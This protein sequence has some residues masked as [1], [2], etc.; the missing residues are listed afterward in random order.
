MW[1]VLE[2]VRQTVCR[3]GM[4]A[5][6]Q[7]VGVA[8]SGG[9]DSVCLLDVLMALAP[10]WDLRLTVL[11][12]DHQLRGADSAQDAEFV[13]QLAASLGLEF[14]LSRVD[15]RAMRR[16]DNLE[17][18]ARRARRE[19]FLG[20]LRE[21]RLDRVA[22]GHTRSDQAETVLFRFLRG[23]GTAGLAGIWPV[24]PE[25][26]VRP[27]IEVDRS[28]VIEYLTARGLPWREDASNQDRSF[29]R[30]RIRHELLPALTRDWNSALC[31]TLA[32]TGVLAQ[33]D[34]QY[35]NGEIGR[36]EASQLRTWG[37]SVLARASAL[38]QL[39]PAAARRLIRRA[40]E[41]ARG[42]LRGV[43]FGHVEQIMRLARRRGGHGGA[44]VPGLRV[45][46]SF[47]WI[48]LAESAAPQGCGYRF[49]LAVPGRYPVPG[50]DVEVSLTLLEVENR[51][52]TMVGDLNWSPGG[53]TLQLRS[54]RPGDRYR[55]M[56]H[57]RQVK[58][59]RLFQQ[60][61]IPL[62]VR[63]FWPIITRGEA[64]IWAGGFGSSADHLAGP[65]SQMA[66][67]VGV[68]GQLAD[69]WRS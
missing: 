42:D 19:F 56:G 22:L 67:R 29:A 64:I 21:G 47:D 54:W 41:R 48:R 23:S 33:E 12:L 3:Y 43:D 52:N 34:E 20:F 30:N 27:L 28:E 68:V 60:A 37:S 66:L 26:L 24:T 44:Q 63:R 51:Y 15:V 16:E 13:R 7:R 6:A 31:Q 50:M 46:R 45:V 14:H 65:A 18:A 8:V 9:A 61:R 5:P 69:D 17:Q 2:R 55:A 4:F 32:Q 38:S 11:H 49:E 25:G 62:W 10:Q 40:I 59:K 36:L 35:W 57:A 39:P 1:V 53:Q 58:L